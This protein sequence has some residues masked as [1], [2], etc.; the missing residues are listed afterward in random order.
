M[1][2]DGPPRLVSSLTAQVKLVSAEMGLVLFLMRI[3]FGESLYLSPML[4]CCQLE[5][6]W[7]ELSISP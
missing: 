4:S 1:F 3:V 5:S 6:E 2:R 7:V